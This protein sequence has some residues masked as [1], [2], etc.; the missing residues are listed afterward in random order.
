MSMDENMD[1]VPKPDETLAN[2]RNQPKLWFLLL[3]A[4]FANSGISQ[5]ATKYNIVVAALDENVLD[6]VVDILS[7]PPENVKSDTLKKALFKQIN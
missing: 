2:L 7:N 5:Y 1:A 4:K 3:E 6:F